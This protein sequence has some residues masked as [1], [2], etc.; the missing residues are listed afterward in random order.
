MARYKVILAYDG[1]RYHGFQRQSRD[2]GHVETQT[3]QGLVESSLQKMGWREGSILAAGRTDAGVHASG[4]V[5]AF[6]L[7]W[8]HP[9]EDLCAALNARLPHDIA[10]ISA[11]SVS[12][13]FHPRYDALARHY[14]YHLYCRKVRDPLKDRYAWHVWPPVELETLNK[15]AIQLCGSHDFSAFG[16]PPQI[17]GTTIRTVMEAIWRKYLGSSLPTLA[18][19]VDIYFDVVANA[20]LY[21][22]VRRLVYVQVAVSQGK[23]EEK[24][25][26]DLL[27]DPPQSV[28]QGLAPS[29]GLTLVGVEYER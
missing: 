7:E 23:L 14:R 9:P 10:A 4:Q 15:A 17:G 20:F 8:N 28:V 21:R 26:V 22:M 6:D 24:T 25:F 29:K 2:H 13:K 27:K 1:T 11:E 12:D 16:T 5:I 18:D 3:V 19:S